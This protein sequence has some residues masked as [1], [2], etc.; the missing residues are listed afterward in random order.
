MIANEAA[1]VTVKQRL[2]KSAR[3]DKKET[4]V[5]SGERFPEFNGALTL[6]LL[7]FFHAKKSPPGDKLSSSYRCPFSVVYL[8]GIILICLICMGLFL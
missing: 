4:R 3:S 8:K 6:T 5:P 1:A 7:S 2:W